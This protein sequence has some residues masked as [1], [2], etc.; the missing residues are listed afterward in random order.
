MADRTA[1]T[2]EIEL[3]ENRIACRIEDAPAPPAHEIREDVAVFHETLQGAILILCNEPAIAADI[4]GHDDG[5]LAPQAAFFHGLTARLKLSSSIARGSP[6]DPRGA[7]HDVK[8]KTT[9]AMPR[10][11]PLSARSSI[12]RYIH[13]V[14]IVP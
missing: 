6:R 13:I 2:A 8:S 12:L 7:Q 10:N 5:D 9:I 14:A 4:G 11:P 3:G 1:S